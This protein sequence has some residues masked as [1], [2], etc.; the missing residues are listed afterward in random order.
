MRHPAQGER[1]WYKRLPTETFSAAG[2]KGK[3]GK[4]T[5]LWK[6]DLTSGQSWTLAIVNIRSKPK[7]VS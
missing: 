5:D 3:A 2:T 1:I 7:K 4:S 6:T